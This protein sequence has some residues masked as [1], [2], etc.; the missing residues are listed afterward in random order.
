MFRAR[1]TA[2][3]LSVL[4]PLTA[5][6]AASAHA[7]PSSAREDWA[8]S[9][10]RVTIDPNRTWDGRAMSLPA[11]GPG[12][13]FLVTHL[14]VTPYFATGQLAAWPDVRW[15]L[16]FALRQPGANPDGSG[17]ILL[18]GVTGQGPEHAEIATPGGVAQQDVFGFDNGMNLQIDLAEAQPDPLEFVVTVSGSCG[19]P[20][21]QVYPEPVVRGAVPGTGR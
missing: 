2:T 7:G 13:H 11:C 17:Q 6:L 9:T 19:V 18:M 1:R 10:V 3:L 5:L 20:F 21:S 15:A 4:L 14:A 16:R 12:E 8:A